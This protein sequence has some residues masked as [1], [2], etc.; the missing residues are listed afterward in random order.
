MTAGHW[1]CAASDA[2]ARNR[3]VDPRQRL[4][5][6]QSRVMGAMVQSLWYQV[7]GAPV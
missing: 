1:L 2:H 7:V 4:R 3:G 5:A 6:D